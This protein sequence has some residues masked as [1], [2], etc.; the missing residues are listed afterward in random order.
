MIRDILFGNSS[1]E[2]LKRGLDAG[3]LRMKVIAENVANVET[4]GYR[5]REVR[6]EE[7]LGEAQAAPSN[8]SLSL[9]RSNAAHLG[10]GA[11]AGAAIARPRIV[12]AASRP[13]E[14][15]ASNVDV[16]RELVEMQKNEI[17]F[18]ALSQVLADKYR[19]L[20]DA[21]RPS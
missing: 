7:L 13:A 3:A 16:E 5:A 19:G 1:I 21:I 15:A 4:P 2:L 18:Q 6:F 12:A 8:A 14:G 10:S 11:G 9:T 17:Q 20:K